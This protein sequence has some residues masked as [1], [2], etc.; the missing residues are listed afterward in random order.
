MRKRLIAGNWKLNGDWSLCQQMVAAADTAQF[1]SDI[2]ICPPAVYLS[3]FVRLLCDSS[4]RLKAG[5]QDV[6]AD[7]GGA[8]TGEVSASML[9]DVGA[10]FGIVGHS[11]RRERF[12]E[13]NQYVAD[14]MLRLCEA[15]L[16][17]IVCVGESLDV[18]E[19]G[20]TLAVIEEQL[21]PIG[22]ALVQQGID[23]ASIAIAY[24]PIWAIGTGKSATPEQAQE[25]H[26]HIRDV[27]ARF[28]DSTAL[29]ILY[30]G[31]VNAQNATALL[32]MDDIDGA[33]VG[34]ASLDPEQFL[35]LA[36]CG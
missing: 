32:G 3:Q 13:S 35:Q 34:G 21:Q 26:A 6:S 22:V 19:A 8:H 17:P 11:E 27:M 12:G 28:G 30:G 5:A 24:E 33:L 29:R 7:T 2:V 1:E 18:R 31:S 23:Q 25:V 20:Q 14:K 9:A 10:Q 16:T 4:S 15:Q 36:G